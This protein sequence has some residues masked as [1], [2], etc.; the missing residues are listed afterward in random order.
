MAPFSIRSPSVHHLDLRGINNSDN[1]HYYNDQQCSTLIRSP[2]GIQCQILLI[3]V[4]KRSHIIDLVN[5]MINLRALNIR[6]RD[7]DKMN[8]DGLIKWLQSRLPSTCTIAKDSR[9]SDDIR[10]WIR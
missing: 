10:L 8:D 1:R 7:R 3:E 9:S 5:K 2:L 6:C 4:E